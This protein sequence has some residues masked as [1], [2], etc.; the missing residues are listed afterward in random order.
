MELGPLLSELRALV[1]LLGSD[2]EVDAG[3]VRR[4][5]QGAVEIAPELDQ[6]AGRM[7]LDAVRA[8]QAA[9]GSRQRRTE[10]QLHTLRS[11]KRAMKGYGGLRSHKS[12]QRVRVKA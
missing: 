9:G 1:A 2:E 3:R 10:E 7:L 5:V 6:D 4:A 11:G 8:L 12:G